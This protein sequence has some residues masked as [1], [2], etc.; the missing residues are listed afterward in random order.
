[1]GEDIE[2]RRYNT[3][4]AAM[5][6]FVNVVNDE[7]GQ[8]SP[9]DLEKFLLIL[10]PFAPFMTEELWH[11]VGNTE[12]IHLQSWPSYDESKLVVDSVQVVIQVNGKLRGTIHIDKD[13]AQD[14]GIVE[15]KAKDNQ[16]ISKYLNGRIKKVIFVPSK[17]INFVVR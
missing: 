5:M 6:T 9:S 1:M 13:Q 8:L 12:S 4:I 15:K 11:R 3:A 17:L 10:A 16:S 2:K 14:Q 7:N